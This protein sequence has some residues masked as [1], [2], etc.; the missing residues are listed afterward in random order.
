MCKP[1][2]VDTNAH[3]SQFSPCGHL[4]ITDTQI[5]RTAAKSL[6]K[7]DISLTETNSRYYGLSLLRTLTRGTLG[8]RIKGADCTYKL[9]KKLSQLLSMNVSLTLRMLSC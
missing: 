2:I 1:L 9:Q 7:I 8:V 5:I 3:Y 6:G 4:T